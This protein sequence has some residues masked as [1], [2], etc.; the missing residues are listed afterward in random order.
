MTMCGIAGYF[1]SLAEGHNPYDVLHRMLQS[2]R[3]RGR[4]HTAIATVGQDPVRGVAGYNRLSIN[5]RSSRG[6][7]PLS[8]EDGSVIAFLNGEIYNYRELRDKLRFRGHTLVTNS[9]TEV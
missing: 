6:N 1:S 7:Q 5:D 8:N 9:D 3:S 2:M 4:D